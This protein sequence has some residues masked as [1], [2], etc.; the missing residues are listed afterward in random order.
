LIAGAATATT[1]VIR[2]SLEQ[3][4]KMERRRHTKRALHDWENEGGAVIPHASHDDDD[5]LGDVAT[6]TPPLKSDAVEPIRY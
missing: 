4:A 5:L 6:R 3:R 2:R 1:W